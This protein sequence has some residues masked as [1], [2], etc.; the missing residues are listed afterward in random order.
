M[1]TFKFEAWPT[2]F[3][4]LNQLFG[5]NQAFYGRFNLPGHEGLDIRAAQGTCIFCV[6]PGRVSRVHRDPDSDNYGIHVRIEHSDGYRTIYAHLQEARVREGDTV[7]AGTL[8]GLA[9]STGNS[10]GPHLHLTLKKTGASHPGFPSNI[11]DPTPFILPLLGW[12][13]PAGPYTEGWAFTE[14]ILAFGNLAQANAGGVSL[15]AAPARN[16]TRLTVIPEGSMFIVTGSRSGEYTPVKVP[17]VTIGLPVAPP[18][19]AAPPPATVATVE[20]WGF[21]ANLIVSGA[22]A[23]IGEFGINL[24]DRPDRNGLN[25]GLLKAG[26]T[27]TVR[28]AVRGEYLPI[29]A[30]RSDFSGPVHLPEPAPVMPPGPVTPPAD[31]LLG[32]GATAFLSALGKEATI[33]SEFGLNL[34]AAPSTAGAVLGVVKG[35]ASVG[36]AGLRRGDFTPIVARRAD[37]VNL[38]VPQPAV[39]KPDPLPDNLPTPPPP[40]QPIHDTT[41]GWAFTGGLTLS[42]EEAIAGPYGINLRAAPRRDAPLK[43]FVPAGSGMIISGPAQGEY[44]PVRVDDHLVQ[45]TPA[46][47]AAPTPVPQPG[48]PP[49]PEPAPVPVID[50][51]PPLI[52][53]AR[54]GLHASADPGDLREEEFREFAAL[55]PGIIKI[56]SGHS[57][58]SVARLAGEHPSATWIVRAFLSFQGGRV[59]SPEQFFNDT[60][61]DVIRSLDQLR[62]KDVVIELHNEPNLTDEGLGASWLDGGAFAAWWS[63]VLARYRQ[64]LPGHRFIYPGL[65]PGPAAQDGAR[66]RADHVQFLEASRAAVEAADGL[67]VH[68]Y[69]ARDYAMEKALAVL[70]DYINRFRTRPIWI[71]EASNNK[72][73]VSP[74][75][76][77]RQYLH[78]WSEL[79]KRPTVQGVTY[80]VAS[81]SDPEF[82]EEIWVGR[83]IGQVIGQR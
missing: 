79:K 45:L 40:P 56:L 1:S 20:G 55:R 26:S 28:G 27:V 41:P 18:A 64:R 6:A 15:R 77:G 68:I 30:R 61:G 9:G 81:A 47:V 36:I 67:A 16:A 66:R 62:Q 50:P 17:N 46:P 3:R 73:G 80:Y 13:E 31:T 59:V 2:E 52:G 75:Q 33:T 24:R 35:F 58:A 83:G 71:T 22:Q 49:A 72:G 43:G 37:V 44:T 12:Q 48:Q 7:D 32:W 65:S 74:E 63:Q 38:A 51:E 76:K 8:L 29:R 11:I 5:V 4:I 53:Q 42:G 69:W 54:I 10:T 39:T 82:A 19:P 34:R 60:I 70:D 57:A 23:V 21:A 78:F 25:I 14:A